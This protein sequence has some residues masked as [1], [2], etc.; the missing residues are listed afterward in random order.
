VPAAVLGH[1]VGVLVVVDGADDGTAGIAASRGA[2]VCVT[3]VN[4][5]QGAALRL[6]Y[7]LAAA[8]G[9]KVVSTLD[10][11]G[12]YDPAELA[13]IAGAILEGEA[14]FVSG[15]RR[16][17]R[18]DTG[19]GL[20]GAGV[21]VFAT[22]ISALTRH[23]VTDP[24]NGFRAMRTEVPLSLALTESQY[25]ASELLV[26]AIMSG[27]RVVERPVVMRARTSGSTKKGGSLRYA[28][29]FCRVILATWA[30]MR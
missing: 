21:V 22:L 20:R 15:S 27:Y 9:S 16:L 17:G 13:E 28:L 24:S 2:S 10:A 1:R 14:D 19:N 3:G 26:G 25:Q 29:S 23:R 18:D 5:G 11:D 30:R 12:Q 7:E 8:H 4:R 6:G